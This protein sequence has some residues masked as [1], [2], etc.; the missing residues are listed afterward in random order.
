MAGKRHGQGVYLY[1]NGDVYQG[2]WEQDMKQ[3]M[4]MYSYVAG[5]KVL[6]R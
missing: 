3:G 1:P 4:G 2:Y 6:D 5:G